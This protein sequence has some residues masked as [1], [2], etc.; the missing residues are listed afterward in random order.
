MQSRSS[1]ARST[2]CYLLALE[3]VLS[4]GQPFEFWPPIAQL[5]GST[6]SQSS[7]ACPVAEYASHPGMAALASLIALMRC[8]TCNRGQHVEALWRHS[9]GLCGSII[10]HAGHQASVL[11][12]TLL[13]TYARCCLRI[14]TILPVGRTNTRGSPV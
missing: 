10:K 5:L 11:Y 3:A 14:S 6:P 7:W 9:Q 1:R 2:L 4:T 8:L 12:P 13:W